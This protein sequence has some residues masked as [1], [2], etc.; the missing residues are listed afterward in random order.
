VDGLAG[1]DEAQP[2]AGA[3]GP[4]E[5]RPAGTL[6]AVV[7]NDRLR[8]AVALGEL[9]EV[10]GQPCARDRHVDDPAGAEPA[11]IVDDVQDAEAPMVDEVTSRGVV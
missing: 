2:D 7:E 5:H 9:V 4:P 3:L 1:L 10:A 8:Q 6:G 11:V